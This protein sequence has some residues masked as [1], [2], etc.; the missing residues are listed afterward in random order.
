MMGRSEFGSCSGELRFGQKKTGIISV[1]V[2][3]DSQCSLILPDLAFSM[4]HIVLS[5]PSTFTTRFIPG[6]MSQGKRRAEGKNWVGER[7]SSSNF[8]QQPK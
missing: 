4:S 7:I 5:L 8:D 6:L 2:L 1:S 3:K